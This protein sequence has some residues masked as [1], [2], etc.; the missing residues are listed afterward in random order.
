MAGKSA[1]DF[2]GSLL[3]LVLWGLFLFFRDPG[4][5]IWTS[6]SDFFLFF[7]FYLQKKGNGFLST[8][9]KRESLLPRDK[10]PSKDSKECILVHPFSAVYSSTVTWNL[11]LVIF[12]IK[13]IVIAKLLPFLDSPAGANDNFVSS[14]ESDHLRHA[15]GGTRVVDVPCGTSRQGSIDDV[16]VVNAEH[17]HPAVLR[18]IKLLL[19]VCY[20]IP[21]NSSDVLNDHSVLFNV[22]SS[23]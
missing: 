17:V 10:Q 5:E 23:I 9:S 3:V 19:P 6:R 16:V 13:L 8:K 12:K 18:F 14:L 1:S 7:F 15:V 4:V 22:S 20:L 21:D 11:V 2:A